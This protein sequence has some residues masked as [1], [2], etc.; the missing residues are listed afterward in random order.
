VRTR[1]ASAKATATAQPSIDNESGFRS[2]VFSSDT[3]IP[4]KTKTHSHS[5]EWV[6]EKL[7]LLDGYHSP[8]WLPVTALQHAIHIANRIW[9]SCFI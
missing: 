9:Q 1:T 4:P 6:S 5:G 8:E 7:D 2:F 3:A